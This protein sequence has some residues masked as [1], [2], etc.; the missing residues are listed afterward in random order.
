MTK[1]GEMLAPGT[2]NDPLQ[3]IDVRD[4]AEWL[5]LLIEGNTHGVFNAVGPGQAWTMGAMLDTCRQVSGKDTKLTWVLADWLEKQ[6]ETEDMHLP[7]D[8]PPTGN[9]AGT[10]LRSNAMAVKAGPPPETR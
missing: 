5:V 8:M 2:P 9:S 6:G 10:H 1:G 7:I 4:L 3:I